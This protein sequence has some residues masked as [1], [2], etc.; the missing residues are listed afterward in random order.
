MIIAIH[1]ITLVSW[2][3]I[4]SQVWV[5]KFWFIHYGHTRNFFRVLWGQTKI[6]LKAIRAN[7]SP[8]TVLC[9]IVKMLNHLRW[10]LTLFQLFEVEKESTKSFSL[11]APDRVHSAYITKCMSMK[12]TNT[13]SHMCTYYKLLEEL[14][15]RTVL[16]PSICTSIYLNIHNES[17]VFC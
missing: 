13:C 17:Y 15:Y 7:L 4:A 1:S 6:I 2:L 12:F 11:V 9:L 14:V 5:H 8:A 16:Y 10:F 3:L